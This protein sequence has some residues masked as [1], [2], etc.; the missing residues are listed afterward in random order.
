MTGKQFM[1]EQ[2]QGHPGVFY[3]NFGMHK[4]IFTHLLKTLQEKS[5]FAASKHVSAIEQLGIFLYAVNKGLS[6]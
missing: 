6:V 1:N 2:L 5:N 3:D 4:H